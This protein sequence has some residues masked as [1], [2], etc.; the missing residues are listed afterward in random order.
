[1]QTTKEKALFIVLLSLTLM[2]L[3]QLVASASFTAENRMSQPED[4]LPIW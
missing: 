3:Q 2:H 1:M 4:Y